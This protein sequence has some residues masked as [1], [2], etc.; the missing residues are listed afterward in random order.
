MYDRVESDDVSTPLPSASHVFISRGSLTRLACDAFLVPTD[1]TMGVRDHWQFE[2]RDAEIAGA[3]SD[4]FRAERTFA[5]FAARD[6]GTNPVPVFTAVPYEGAGDDLAQFGIRLEAF[7]IAAAQAVPEPTQS[8]RPTRLFAF[9]FFGTMGGGS[10]ARRGE[11]LDNLLGA[12]RRV[13]AEFGVDVDVALILKSDKALARAN[14]MRRNSPADWWP[15]LS[16]AELATATSLA[17]HARNG[18]LVPFMGAGVSVSA[19]APTWAGL[20]ESIA[21]DLEMS[22]DQIENLSRRSPLDQAAYLRTLWAA[23]HRDEIDDPT[24]ASGFNARVAELVHRPR[25][26]LAPLLIAGISSEQAITLNYDRLYEQ[27]VEDSTDSPAAEAL[28]IIGGLENLA[29]AES[30]RW[31]LN[32][33]GSVDDPSTIVLTRDDYLGFNTSRQA[34][35]ALVKATLIT[36]HLLF[37][38]FGL[39]DDHFHEILHDVTRALGSPKEDGIATALALLRDPLDDE[40]WSGRLKMVPML[41][42]AENGGSDAV[43]RAARKLEIFLDAVVALSSDSHSHLL[44]DDFAGAL[45]ADSLALRA[46]LLAFHEAAR[47][48]PAESKSWPRVAALLDELG[49][50]GGRTR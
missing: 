47:V 12:A 20:L 25:Y 22:P 15:E 35:S 39:A 49:L 42:E 40:V 24:K 33:H 21:E 43:G 45:G 28:R 30:P 36:H 5:V 2:D 3:V 6:R 32:L 26:G 14:A 19:A 48:T 46:E 17:E 34:L 18:R 37:V 9:P 1:R 38:G 50:P 41:D 13:G 23:T 7:L 44:D 29:R 10:G 31:L 27:A 11:V 16:D 8:G 4:D